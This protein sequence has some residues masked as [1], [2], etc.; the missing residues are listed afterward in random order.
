[1]SPLWIAPAL[2]AVAGLVVFAVLVHG[3]GTAARELRG[4]LEQAAGLRPAL[5]NLR[6]EAATSRRTVRRLGPR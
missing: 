5:L 2:V 6:S 4:E 1:M 3:V